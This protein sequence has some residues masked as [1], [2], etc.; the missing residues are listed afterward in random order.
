MKVIG[1][2]YTN[3]LIPNPYM[4]TKDFKEPEDESYSP[5]GFE[6]KMKFNIAGKQTIHG[7][8]LTQ[9]GKVLYA[10]YFEGGIHLDH[11][12]GSIEVTG[13]T[14]L[15]GNQGNQVTIQEEE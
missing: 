13:L 8:Y 11:H 14:L 2:L 15:T 10:K 7:F 9:G 12:G 5:V 4:E 6:A 1:H 3:L